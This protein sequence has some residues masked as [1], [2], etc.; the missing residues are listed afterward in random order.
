MV[1]AFEDGGSPQAS[2]E[3]E[4]LDFHGTSGVA[5]YYGVSCEELGL[6]LESAPP[7]VIGKRSGTDGC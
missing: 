4:L 7:L 6:P 2:D 5:H 1:L 3:A